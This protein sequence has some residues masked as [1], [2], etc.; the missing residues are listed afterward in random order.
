MK[1]AASLLAADFAR[2]ADEVRRVEG[3]VDCLHLD[4]MDGH[5]VPNLTFGPVVANALR[6]HTRLPYEIHLMI[7]RPARYAPQFTVGPDDSITFHVEA[8]DPPQETLGVI[9]NLACQVGISFRPG[10]PLD[11]V[12]PYLDAVDLVLVMS[13][14]PGFGGQAFLPAALDRIRSL[15][16][17]IGKRPVAVAVDGG[18]GLHNVRSVVEAGADLIVAGSAI[19]QQPDPRA[20][21]REL[22]TRAGHTK[23]S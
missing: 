20:A 15:R 14:E 22:W 11:A 7:E 4:V 21:A 12:F 6:Q 5:F 1:L 17:E 8:A 23:R 16:A 2:L 18:I 13:V 3:V 19:F 9:R 10:T